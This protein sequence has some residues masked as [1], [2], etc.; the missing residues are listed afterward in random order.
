MSSAQVQ[1]TVRRAS[2]PAC[3]GPVAWSPTLVFIAELLVTLFICLI[4]FLV[5]DVL[6]LHGAPI[7][8]IERDPSLSYEA[9]TE[10]VPTRTLVVVSTIVPGLVVLLGTGVQILRDWSKPGSTRTHLIHGF[11]LVLALAQALLTNKAITDCTKIAVGKQRPNFFV[12]AAIRPFALRLKSSPQTPF[13]LSIVPLSLSPDTRRPCV[14]TQAMLRPSTA[15]TSAHTLQRQHQGR[16]ATL[17]SAKPR[18][19]LLGR[20]S[21]ASLPGMLAAVSP[22]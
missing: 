1:P 15:A 20:H 3:G 4:A 17:P 6:N 7:P 18:P 12:S 21:A 2:L 19:R 8:F 9:V 11:F 5:D 16:S 22:A 13:P 10:T 14:T